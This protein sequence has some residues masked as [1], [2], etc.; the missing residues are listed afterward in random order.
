M[1]VCVCVCV[2]KHDM[3]T[4][5]GTETFRH[6]KVHRR[7]HTHTQAHTSPLPLLRSCVININTLL[8]EVKE[9]G[10]KL[11]LSC[12]PSQHPPPHPRVPLSPPSRWRLHGLLGAAI[13]HHVIRLPFT[14]RTHTRSL[15]KSGY[16]HTYTHISVTLIH[17][18]YIFSGTVPSPFIKVESES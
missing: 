18:M 3:Q 8:F 5:D 1:C 9:F 13:G 12:D 15:C 4:P 16:K 14:K 17:F 11:Y 2:C 7:D 6:T 10:F